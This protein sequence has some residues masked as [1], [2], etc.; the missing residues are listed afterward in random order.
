MKAAS[1]TSP[2]RYFDKVGKSPYLLY[3][4]LVLLLSV[5]G[6]HKADEHKRFIRALLP[7]NY[8]PYRKTS[9][10]DVCLPRRSSPSTL[11]AVPM[12]VKL[13]TGTD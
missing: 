10:P 12:N 1:R 4:C 2:T 11:C 5:T 9:A 3:I 13:H 6:T 7:G 8:V